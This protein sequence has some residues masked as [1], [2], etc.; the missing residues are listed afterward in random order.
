MSGARAEEILAQAGR[1]SHS[2]TRDMC[3]IAVSCEKTGGASEFG[4]ASGARAR[5]A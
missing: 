3:A 5:S 1:M 2:E 4:C